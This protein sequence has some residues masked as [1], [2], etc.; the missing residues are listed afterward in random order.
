MRDWEWKQN[1][2]EQILVGAESTLCD[3]QASKNPFL[4]L[5][6]SSADSTLLI[7]YFYPVFN[8]LEVWKSKF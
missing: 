8:H 5:G 7:V 1:E 4:L 3:W 2:E 6:F